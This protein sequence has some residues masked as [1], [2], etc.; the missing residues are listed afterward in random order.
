MLPTTV[1]P[2]AIERVVT[3]SRRLKRRHR[4]SSPMLLLL[5]LV[6]ALTMQRIRV[7]KKW[8][9]NCTLLVSFYL[10]AYPE[11]SRSMT[12]SICVAAFVAL[13]CFV[14]ESSFWMT[15]THMFPSTRTQKAL[16][17]W[18]RRDEIPKRGKW[19]NSCFRLLFR[20]SLRLYSYLSLSV[21]IINK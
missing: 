10:V 9:E 15:T 8:V 21:C 12:L 19:I 11:F 7:A 13:R 3:Q 18:R 17:R 20:C 5:Q 4:K 16:C 1:N 6:P 2:S 14:V